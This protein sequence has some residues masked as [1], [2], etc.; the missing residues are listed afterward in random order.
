MN[1]INEVQTLKQGNQL[2]HHTATQAL[3]LMINNK[4]KAAP[5]GSCSY[6]TH[7]ARRPPFYKLMGL[8]N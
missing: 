7:L 8:N 5:T 2:L 4:G 3:N 1:Q 6:G